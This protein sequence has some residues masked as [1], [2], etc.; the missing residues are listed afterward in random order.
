MCLGTTNVTK[1]LLKNAK[2]VLDIRMN[3]I[4]TGKFD[5]ACFCNTFRD[6]QWKLTKGAIAV[7]KGKKVFQIV[8]DASEDH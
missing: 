3:L 6:G 1:L 4:S 2:Q 8:C 5:D 7:A